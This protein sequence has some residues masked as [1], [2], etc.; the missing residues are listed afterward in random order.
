[1]EKILGRNLIDLIIIIASIAFA[2]PAA[3]FTFQDDPSSTWS[4]DA[5]TTRSIN[6]NV[7]T[8]ENLFAQNLTA[9]PL[10]SLNFAIPFIWPDADSTFMPMQWRNDLNG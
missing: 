1:M 9:I 7:V 5:L 8:Y 4:G 3:A 6:G 10:P 2:G